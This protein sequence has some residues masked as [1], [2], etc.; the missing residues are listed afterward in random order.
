MCAANAVGIDND[1]DHDFKSTLKAALHDFGQAAESFNDPIQWL[2]RHTGILALV[3]IQTR[4]SEEVR[5]ARAS[6]PQ[7]I[8]VG[9]AGVTPGPE[10]FRQYLKAGASGLIATDQAPP[11]LTNTLV[12]ALAGLAVI[13]PNIAQALAS[14][15]EEPPPHVDLTERD[16]RILRLIARGATRKQI[17]ETNGYSDRHLRRVTADLFTTIGA[18]NRA[19]AAAIT[20]R[21]G[22]Y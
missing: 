16:L 8:I 21:W 18:T 15:L 22:M 3:A 9:I 4:S 6:I 20:T 11:E 5:A 1:M 10:T 7:S 2:N 19:H 13:P 12:A 14:R 17:A